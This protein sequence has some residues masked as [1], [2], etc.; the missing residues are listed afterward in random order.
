MPVPSKSGQLFK[1]RESRHTSAL[2]LSIQ[3]HALH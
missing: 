2:L 1:M 3:C